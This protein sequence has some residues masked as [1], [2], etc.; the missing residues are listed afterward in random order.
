[1]GRSRDVGRS[2]VGEVGGEQGKCRGSEVRSSQASVAR[3]HCLRT[4]WQIL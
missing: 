2:I 3:V 1:M 4:D